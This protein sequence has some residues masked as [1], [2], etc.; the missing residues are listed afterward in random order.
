MH[1][2]EIVV[3]Q[4]DWFCSNLEHVEFIINKTLYQSTYHKL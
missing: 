1:L 3:Q 4:I 2:L